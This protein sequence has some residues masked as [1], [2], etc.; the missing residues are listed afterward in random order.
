MQRRIQQRVGQRGAAPQSGM[1]YPPEDDVK[2]G[3][4]FETSAADAYLL[5]VGPELWSTVVRE[6]PTPAEDTR[7]AL[8]A[9]RTALEAV[10]RLRIAGSV[11]EDER[12][13]LAALVAEAVE[14]QER[15]LWLWSLG[16][17]TDTAPTRAGGSAAGEDVGKD[18]GPSMSGG[19]FRRFA[20]TLL[21]LS[22]V[23]PKARP[24]VRA[25]V[26]EGG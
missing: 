11:A 24:I 4:G 22:W 14:G 15:A 7:A 8:Q 2:E 25:E 18:A 21:R 23:L 17:E 3:S 9:I 16:R 19:R 10:R 26:R 5:R 6:G 12:C 20:G 13:E 1:G